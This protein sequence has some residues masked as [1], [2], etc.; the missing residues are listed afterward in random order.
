MH[1]S[2]LAQ[3]NHWQKVIAREAIKAL[4]N[5]DYCG[6]LHWGDF[7]GREEWLWGQP[8]GM[9]R[10]GVN[11]GRMLA[12]LDRMTPGDMPQFE[13]SLVMAE[14]GFSRLNDAAVKHMIIISDGDPSPPSSTVVSRMKAQGVKITTV[15]VGTHGPAGNALLQSIATQTG[16]KYYVVNN[17]ATLPRIYQREARRVARPL[18]YERNPGF[19]PQLGFQHEMIQGLSGALPA[20]TGFVLTSLKDSPLVEVSLFSPQPTGKENATILASWNYG[21]GKAIAF[22][23]DAGKRWATSWTGWEGYDK[24][25]SQVVRW[26]MRPVG[27]TGKFTVSTDVQEGKIKVVVTRFG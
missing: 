8:N 23:T 9:V 17:P 7:S 18:V 14:R 5:Q 26:S 2:E 12:L 25:F 27:D 11:R 24:L 6:L 20:I 1:A 10:V 13:T 16:G 21:L 19:Q 22:T 15:A 4:G 3:G